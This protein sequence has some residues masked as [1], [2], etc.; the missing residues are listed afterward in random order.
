MN[1]TELSNPSISEPAAKLEIHTRRRWL[2]LAACS[3]IVFSRMIGPPIWAITPSTLEQAFG[4][5]NDLYRFYNSL[6]AVPQMLFLILGGVAGDLWGRRRVLLVGMLGFFGLNMLCLIAPDL[7]WL[8]WLRTLSTWFGALAAPLV[9]ATVRL[10]FTGQEL[11]L[12]LLV[13]TGALSIGSLLAP[14]LGVVLDPLFGWRAMFVAPIVFAILGIFFALRHT[15]ESMVSGTNRRVDTIGSAAW[16]GLL[17]VLLY[18]ALG[19]TTPAGWTKTVTLAALFVGVIDLGFLIWYERHALRRSGRRSPVSKRALAVV[20]LV[21]AL[22]NMVLIGFFLQLFGFFSIARNYGAVWGTLALA[23]ALPA[24][25]I[26]IGVVAKFQQRL[27][28][29]VLISCGMG[30][31]ALAACATAWGA[32]WA[33]YWWFI[34]PMMLLMMSFMVVATAWTTLFFVAV[35]RDTAGVNAAIS[36]GAGLIGSVLGGTLPAALLVVFG[37]RDFVARLEAA[38][39]P[40][41]VVEQALPVLNIALRLDSVNQPASSIAAFDRLVAGYQLAYAAGFAQVLYLLAGVCLVCAVVVWF[42]LQRSDMAALVQN[43]GE[44]R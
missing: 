10:T 11:P 15:T 21:G 9:L 37:E 43:T 25:V 40:Q 26:V 33:P 27:D 14:L 36:N 31:M 29:R 23:P 20:L 13:Y 30:A 7:F 18:A 24:V 4:A 35:Q 8:I 3:L 32:L 38:G 44:N 34:G 5:Q 17:L 41:L 16:A 22:M 6:G 28:A 12:A 19:A 2:V 1:T 39:A 42:G